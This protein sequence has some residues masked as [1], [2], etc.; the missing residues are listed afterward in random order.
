[1]KLLIRRVNSAFETKIN[2]LMKDQYFLADH[3]FAPMMYTRSPN[4]KWLDQ[5]INDQS[6]GIVFF[7]IF[8]YFLFSVFFKDF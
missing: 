7:F 8:R 5:A 4:L 3:M 2:E 6:T 1:M